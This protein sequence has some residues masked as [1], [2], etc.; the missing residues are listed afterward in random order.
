MAARVQAAN[1]LGYLL[2]SAKRDEEPSG[3]GAVAQRMAGSQQ[4]WLD[5]RYQ[6]PVAAGGSPERLTDLQAGFYAAVRLLRH[7][8]L[9]A[10][11]ARASAAA[12]QRAVPVAAVEVLGVEVRGRPSVGSG[13]EPAAEHPRT[14]RTSSANPG[15]FAGFGPYSLAFAVL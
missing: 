4:Q 5:A 3:H 8:G 9:P 11:R 13:Q 10:G 2:S 12:A 7:A 14:P 6:D 15:V 1:H